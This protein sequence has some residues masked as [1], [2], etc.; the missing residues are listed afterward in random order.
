[1]EN[2]EP[3][4]TGKSSRIYTKIPYSERAS[5]GINDTATYAGIGKSTVYNWIAAGLIRS[6]RIGGRRLVDRQS[7]DDLL[8]GKAAG[9]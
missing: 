3:G 9:G 5:L 4:K 1:M 7:V 6:Q 8:R 2:L